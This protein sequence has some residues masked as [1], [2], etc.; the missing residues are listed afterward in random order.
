M[1]R[2]QWFLVIFVGL[3]LLFGFAAC[4]FEMAQ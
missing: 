3:C 2:F 4:V 1:S